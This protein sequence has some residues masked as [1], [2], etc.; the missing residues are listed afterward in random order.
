MPGRR[1]PPNSV[2]HELSLALSI[3]VLAEQEAQR[4]GLRQID[5]LRLTVGALSGV[6]LSALELALQSALAG[7]IAE[8]A[9]VD[10][11][12]EAASGRCTHCGHVWPL[13]QLY[14]PCPVCSG[15]GADILA[16]RALRVSAIEGF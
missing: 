7:T 10:I 5:V 4:A 1:W 11:L 2:M 14:D 16:G 9:R 8:T 13:Q 6:E 3:A 15:V 12:H